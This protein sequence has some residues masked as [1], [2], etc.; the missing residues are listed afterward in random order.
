M[1]ATGE[2]GA[3]VD[4]AGITDFHVHVFP[5]DLAPRAMATVAGQAPDE[6]RPRL[7]G[8]VG[9]LMR[10]MDAAGIRR[11]VVCNV[12]TAPRQV[13]AILA[14]SLSIRSD[15]IVPL[16]SVHPDCDDG[17]AEVHRTA[18]SGLPGI[19][20]HPMYQD[21]ALDE[22]RMWPI[23]EA[24]AARGL[25]LVLHA[26]CDM[27]YPLSDDRAD[28]RRLI[29]VHE[30]F[31]GIPIVAAHMGGWLR[32][33]EVAAVLAGSGVYLETSYSL[34]RAAPEEMRQILDRH[35]VD[36]IMFGTDSPWQ[37]QADTIRLVRSTWPD[38]ADQEKVLAGNAARLLN[39][40][41]ARR[42]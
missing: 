1:T 15:R 4:S 21:F 27:A 42:R 30:A 14:W 39:E 41:E 6:A 8:S 36:R 22:A 40:A 33:R 7:D 19:K 26:G 13:G 28:P 10:S 35:P 38:P 23:Y 32:W 5:D 29:K 12:A 3:G 25:I 18:D 31:P 11:S 24:I 34:D 20:M 37:G 2:P 9:D 17:P 16:N